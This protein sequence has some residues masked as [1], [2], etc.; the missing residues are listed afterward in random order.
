MQLR[1]F[2]LYEIFDIFFTGDILICL[3]TFSV[4]MFSI[5]AIGFRENVLSFL[6]M[7]IRETGHTLQWPLFFLKD[8]ICIAIFVNGH[9][10][11]ISVKSF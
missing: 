11:T 6:Y 1:F 5:L 7:Y 10:V 4:K 8:Q 3:L 9:P 2:K